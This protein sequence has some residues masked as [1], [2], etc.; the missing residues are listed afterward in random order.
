MGEGG[1]WS[2]VYNRNILK[3]TSGVYL[4]IPLLFDRL[5]FRNDLQCISIPAAMKLQ[6]GF[7]IDVCVQWVTAN[8]RR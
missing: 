2:G 7:A 3:S 5:K 8:G 6:P 4:R 1:P